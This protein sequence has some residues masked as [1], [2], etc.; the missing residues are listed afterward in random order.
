MAFHPNF[1]ALA[2]IG[3]RILTRGKLLLRRDILQTPNLIFSKILQSQALILTSVFQVLSLKGILAVVMT[4]YFPA[5]KSTR[6][7]CRIVCI[8]EPSCLADT[9][10]R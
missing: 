4:C 1:A 8:I 9:P 2:L 3:V 10:R 6:K 5:C 7:L